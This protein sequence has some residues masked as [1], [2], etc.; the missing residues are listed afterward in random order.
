MITKIYVY[1]TYFIKFHSRAGNTDKNMVPF[2][3]DK[4]RERCVLYHVIE[5]AYYINIAANNK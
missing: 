1:V 5:A 3:T 4:R 2:I